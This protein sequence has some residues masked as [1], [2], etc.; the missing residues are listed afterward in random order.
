MS[1]LKLKNGDQWEEIP[2]IKGDPGDDGFSPEV[3]VEEIPGGHQV[4]ITD[5]DG[6]HSFNVMDGVDGASVT[7]LF[8]IDPVIL[9]RSYTGSI[10]NNPFPGDGIYAPN[11]W[12]NS[13]AVTTQDRVFYYITLKN[14]ANET[15]YNAGPIIASYVFRI[16]G[17][18]VYLDLL[19]GWDYE[20]EGQFLPNT[21][22]ATLTERPTYISYSFIGDV[23][24]DLSNRRLSYWYL[25]R[26]AIDP[27]QK[28]VTFNT[29]KHVGFLEQVNDF[30]V[31]QG[32]EA[33]DTTNEQARRFRTEV[34]RENN[35]TKHAFRIGSFNVARY[36]QAHWYKIKE[37]LQNYG[38]DI[39]GLQEVSWPNGDNPNAS[40]AD[41][42]TK[43]SEYFA[44]WQFDSFSTN[45]AYGEFPNNGTYP[46][47][48]RC[49]MAGNG[50]GVDSSVETFLQDQNLVDGDYRYVE[51]CVMSLPR[52]KDKRGSENLK[53]SIYNTQLE[54]R[55]AS[56]TQA[57][58]R[59]ILAMAQADPNP[60]V[61]IMGDTNDFTLDKKVW[62]IF[63]EGGFTPVV[64]TNTSTTA[65]TEDF[66]CIDNFFVS[67]R[68]SALDWNVVWAQDWPWVRSTGV[69]ENMLSD[70]DF[71]YADLQ[72]D[73]SDIR[74]VNL[75]LSHCTTTWTRGWLS[76]NETVTITITPDDGY[77]LP[78]QPNKMLDC[79]IANPQALSYS[80]GTITID[81]S[82]LIGDVFIKIVAT[83]VT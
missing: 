12:G 24:A 43:L 33:L 44:S 71:V 52:Y 83:E 81:G 57:Q 66:N 36:G 41:G 77:Q 47:N 30:T 50:Y 27:T 13:G 2:S 19:Y 65:G 29:D 75:F 10:V 64:N 62:E 9:T 78:A 74:C 5:A 60:F 32:I 23:N 45:G 18:N 4:T 17:L 48:V 53:L 8:D 54:V 7:E 1:V 21:L 46:N 22:V 38:L 79:M 3:S 16:E 69:K 15:L 80:N 49:M 63:E 42:H 35:R 20:A 59:E 40:A 28:R 76:D 82:K 34:V 6:D 67:S 31:Q 26:E 25:S 39:C 72:L 51:K 68:I 73:Y 37:C 56:T 61:I 58:A 55:G 70:H 11:P 14:A